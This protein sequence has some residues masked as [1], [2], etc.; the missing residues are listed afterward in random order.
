[1]FRN[2]ELPLYFGAMKARC[3]VLHGRHRIVLP[4]NSF[5]R[6]FGSRQILKS[7]CSS[8]ICFDPNNLNTVIFRQKYPVPTMV[9]IASRLYSAKVCSVLNAKNGFWHLKLDEE[10]SHLTTFHTPFCHYRRRFRFCRFWQHPLRG[11]PWSQQK[12]GGVKVAVEKLQLFSLNCSRSHQVWSVN[13][14]RKSTNCSWGGTPN[15]CKEVAAFQW[16][17]SVLCKTPIWS[18]WL[19]PPTSPTDS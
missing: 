11:F 16:N 15:W 6:T 12:S 2:L 10:S 9:D 13:S 5:V 19:G 7:A 14:S 18:F 3:N 17:C 1:M 4:K 8:W